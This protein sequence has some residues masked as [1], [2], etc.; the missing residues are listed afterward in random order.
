MKKPMKYYPAPWSKTLIT[1]TSLVCGVLIFATLSLMVR[2][3]EVFTLL[4][5]LPLAIIIGCS[6]LTV[7]GYTITVDAILVHRLFWKTRLPTN[8]LRTARYEPSAMSGGIR[9]FGIGGL[10]SFTGHFQNDNLGSYFAYV[11]DPSKAV[12]LTYPT[13]TIVISPGKPEEFVKE[14]NANKL[15]NWEKSHEN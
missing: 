8:D 10:F 1:M 12:V 3:N 11:T 2:S 7:R 5:L 13:R 14:I 6:L 15:A 9:T 4:N